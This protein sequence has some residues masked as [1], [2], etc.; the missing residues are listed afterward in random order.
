MG[1]ALNLSLG[2]RWV[3]LRPEAMRPEYRAIEHRIVKVIGGFGAQPFTIG[4][5]LFVRGLDGDEWR[6]EGTD[7]ERLATQSEIPKEDGDG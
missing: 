6:A 1:N 5:A 2:G 3:V 4:T 7:V